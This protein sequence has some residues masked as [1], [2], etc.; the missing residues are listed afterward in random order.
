MEAPVLP[1][2][3]VKKRL[4]PNPRCEGNFVSKEPCRGGVNADKLGIYANR[5]V[6]KSCERSIVLTKSKPRVSAPAPIVV[7]KKE[8]DVHIVNDGHHIWVDGVLLEDVQARHVRPK[9]VENI[10]VP[11]HALD[12]VAGEHDKA[13]VICMAKVSSCI[14]LPC[15]HKSLCI[16]CSRDLALNK[17]RGTVSCPICRCGVEE[18]KVVYE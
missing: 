4:P 2:K 18:I 3:V 1:K 6:C 15:A 10:L 8:E 16:G 12:A 5:S 9:L 7:E 13:C 14:I 11:N 17:E